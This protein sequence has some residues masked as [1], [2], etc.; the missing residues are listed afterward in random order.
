MNRRF[1]LLYLML[2]LCGCASPRLYNAE[3]VDKSNASLIS[4]AYVKALIR[5]AHTDK[6]VE[7]R[8]T[9]DGIWVSSGKFVVRYACYEPDQDVTNIH[10]Y[11]YEKTI[12]I[13]SGYHYQVNCFHGKDKLTLENIGWQD[14]DYHTF[15]EAIDE[16]PQEVREENRFLS[17]NYFRYLYYNDWGNSPEIHFEI[18]TDNQ[19]KRLRARLEQYKGNLLYLTLEAYDK[20]ARSRDAMMKAIAPTMYLADVGSCPKIHDYYAQLRKLF[21][22]RVN[23][24]ISGPE[25]IYTDSPDIY[26]YFMGNGNSAMVSLYTLEDHDALYKTTYAAIDYVKKCGNKRPEK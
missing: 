8:I 2:A 6:S 5:P 15:G 21:R 1:S 7:A 11:P 13:E 23:N 26:R 16:V 3:P 20:G 9:D 24:P 10:T 14:V 17:G 19:T 18:Y 12:R 25:M 22:E 4:A